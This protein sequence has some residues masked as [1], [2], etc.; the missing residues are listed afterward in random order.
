[1]IFIFLGYCKNEFSQGLCIGSSWAVLRLL[2]HLVMLTFALELLPEEPIQR[3]CEHPFYQFPRKWKPYCSIISSLTANDLVALYQFNVRIW[4]SHLAKIERSLGSYTKLCS[5]VHCLMES[6]IA[7]FLQVGEH[8]ITRY[9]VEYHSDGLLQTSAIGL[10]YP[11]RVKSATASDDEL[12]I[13]CTAKIG[14]AYWQS[15]VQKTRIKR[16]GRM[17]ES[18]SDGASGKYKWDVFLW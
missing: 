5:I 8:F 18:R 13:K 11:V 10:Q 16:Q 12:S 17:L 6:L 3:P 9:P 1:M 14:N 15:V 7:Y 4:S 2:S